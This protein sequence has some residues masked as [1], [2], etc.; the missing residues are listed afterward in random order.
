MY[1][2][3]LELQFLNMYYYSIYRYYQTK[4][5]YLLPTLLVCAGLWELA[6]IEFLLLECDIAYLS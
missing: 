1:H 4:L 3:Q 6:E 2:Y 5:M